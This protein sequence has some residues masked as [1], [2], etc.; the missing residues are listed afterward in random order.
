MGDP[1][2]L[3]VGDVHGCAAELAS[4]VERTGPTR[5]ILVGDLFTRG[6]DPVGVWRLIQELGA[7]AVRGNQDQ[8]VLEE[9]S[10]GQDLPEAAFRWLEQTPWLLKSR[11]WV[12]VHAGVNPRDWRETRRKEALRLVHW[13]EGSGR[14]W[15][16]QYWG[17]RLVI[18]GH[19]GA[20]GLIDRRP[21]SLGL[22]TACVR[23][24][25]LT[26]YLLEEDRVVS[27]P[28]RQDYT[29]LTGRRAPAARSTARRTPGPPGPP[30]R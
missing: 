13:P 4:L 19:S 26:G 2:T 12:V 17:R 3:F 27:V 22:D 23:G 25:A 6:P 5:V 30:G 15:W 20:L 16:E 14:Y 8:R 7:E 29:A 18:H 21:H 28:A 11:D 10:R 24:G 9:W 1:R